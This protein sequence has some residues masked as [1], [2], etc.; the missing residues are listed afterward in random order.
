MH[1]PYQGQWHK[2]EDKI[3]DDI[4]EAVDIYHFIAFRMAH[5]FWVEVE[6]EIPGSF[7]G[8]TGEDGEEDGDDGPDYEYRTSDPGGDTEAFVNAEDPVEEEEEG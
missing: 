1:P 8:S 7:D 6:K 4:A 5:C 2:D 3:R